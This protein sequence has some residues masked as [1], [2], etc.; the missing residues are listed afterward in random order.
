MLEPQ[1]LEN[2]NE[3]P[4]DTPLATRKFNAGPGRYVVIAPSDLIALENFPA[5]LRA[6]ITTGNMTRGVSVPLGLACWVAYAHFRKGVS[7]IV[8]IAAVSEAGTVRYLVT[9]KR[10]LRAKHAELTGAKL[11]RTALDPYETVRLALLIDAQLQ[12]RADVLR[13]LKQ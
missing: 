10:W 6:R 13:G 8:R 4:I 3:I 2:Q 7:P 5:W 12:R 9:E 11:P 1:H